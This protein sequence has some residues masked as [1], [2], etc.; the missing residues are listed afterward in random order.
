MQ[1]R[2]LISARDPSTVGAMRILVE[3]FL[4]SGQLKLTL[5]TQFPA[6]EALSKTFQSIQHISVPNSSDDDELICH[7]L[8]L[9]DEVQPDIVLTG[10][11]GPDYGID[12]A[13]LATCSRDDASPYAVQSYWGDINKAFGARAQTYLV[14]DDFAAKLTSQKTGKKTEVIGSLKYRDY[15][16]LDVEQ[17]RAGFREEFAMNS[18][19]LVGLIG[20]PIDLG[21]GYNNTLQVVA[22]FLAKQQHKGIRVFYRPHP[23]ET[24]DQRKSTQDT[25]FKKGITLYDG[26]KVQLEALLCGMDLVLS[27]FSTCGYDLQQLA[28][29]SKK[30]IAVPVYLMFNDKLACWFQEKT[31][32]ENIPMSDRGMAILIESESQLTEIFD[33]EN[34]QL[35]KLECWNNVRKYFPINP[36]RAADLVEL[37]MNNYRAKQR[38]C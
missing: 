15:H 25:F 8:K 20:Q 12:E 10:V 3:E 19:L 35:K 4:N 36:Y 32:L 29:V 31:G 2:I 16:Q 28:L 13:L 26:E 11:S 17:I 37:V 7:A 27:A 6:T 30:P 23:K 21:H 14:I 5:A 1:P 24:A 38:L 34:V 18:N 33:L 22:D 9:L